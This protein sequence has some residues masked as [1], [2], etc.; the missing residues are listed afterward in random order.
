[1]ASR[2][3]F[4]D[5]LGSGTVLIG[6]SFTN[7]WTAELTRHFRFQFGYVEEKPCINDTLTGR[8]WTLTK[9]ANGQSSEDYMLVCRLPHSQTNGFVVIAAGL[10][11]YGTEEAGRII[12]EPDSLV[13]ILKKLP[14]G[15]A[16][17]NMEV[18]LHAE[19]IGDAPALPEVVAA[20]TW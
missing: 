3:E 16:N 14:E 12:T 9:T 2:A 6:A 17:R 10:N 19:V 4:N 20:H 11:G 7:R 8:R 13:P 18:I 1:L 5:L 15:W